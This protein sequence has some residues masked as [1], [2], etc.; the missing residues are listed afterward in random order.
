MSAMSLGELYKAANRALSAEPERQALQHAS[1]MALHLADM[2]SWAPACIDPRGEVRVALDAIRAAARLAYD[3][4]GHAGVGT[5]H[6]A[7]ADL[8]E[9]IARHDRD[10]EAGNA[11][12]EYIVDSL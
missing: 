10:L 6:D 8:A 5:L 11:G 9:A 12:A 3:Q 1:S 4:C 7:I 2:V